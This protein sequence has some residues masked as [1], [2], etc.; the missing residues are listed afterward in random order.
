M[1]G[2][3]VGIAYGNV[4]G[5]ARWV[6]LG[7]TGVTAYS[8]NGGT[9]WVAGGSLAAGTWSS[10]TYGQ[11]VWIAVSTGGTDT[12]YST[13][14]VTWVAGGALP[15]SSTWISITYGK[16]K[17]V[18][19]SSDG[20]IDPAYSVDKGVTWSKIGETGYP[21][22]GTITNIR[23]GQGVFVVTTSS[24]NNMASS[25]DGIKWT[26][27]AITRASGT[28]A[29][30]AVNGNPSQSGIWAIIPSASTTAAS[31]AVLGSTAKARAYVADN[32]IY[33]IRTDQHMD[34]H[35]L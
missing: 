19:V 30:I 32:K 10:I 23:Y 3:A 21:G 8:V 29:K 4:S 20:A 25:E 9:S 17:F 35:Q 12:S 7:S 5:A 2:L 22:S 24:S 14:G 33:A 26:T 6:V 34:Q 11:G 1:S 16:N 31:S 18:A 27:R 13:N 28:G 15:D